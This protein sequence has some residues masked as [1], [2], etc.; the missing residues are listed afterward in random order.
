MVDDD[1]SVRE[2]LVGLVRSLGVEVQE[3]ASA[4]A[5]LARSDP[6]TPACI[7]LDVKMPGMSGVELHAHLLAQGQRIP[8]VVISAAAHAAQRERLLGL[9][10]I[11]FLEKPFDEETLVHVVRAAVAGNSTREPTP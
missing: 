5:F 6:G 11:A 3:F 8:T 10:V 4:E 2:S 7:I 9:G 1:I